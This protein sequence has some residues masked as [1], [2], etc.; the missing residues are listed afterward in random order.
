MAGSRYSDKNE[1]IELSRGHRGILRFCV[2]EKTLYLSTLGMQQLVG[3]FVISIVRKH[4]RTRLMMIRVFFDWDII[5]SW[6]RNGLK[7]YSGI[8]LLKLYS[9]GHV[10]CD[11]TDISMAI[12]S[13]SSMPLVYA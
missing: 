3:R 11:S 10:A 2:Y 4:S 12:L 1:P 6:E 5:P 7:V 13:Q 8:Y 9:H